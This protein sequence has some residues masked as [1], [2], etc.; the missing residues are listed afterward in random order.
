MKDPESFWAFNGAVEMF[1]TK[2]RL[3]FEI[4]LYMAYST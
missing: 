4:P 3:D 2:T 1:S